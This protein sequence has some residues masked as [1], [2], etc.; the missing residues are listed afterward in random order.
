MDGKRI[1]HV[2]FAPP[3][4]AYDTFQAAIAASIEFN[5]TAEW[6]EVSRRI[7]GRRITDINFADDILQ[8][9]LDNSSCVRF[10]LEQNRIVPKWCDRPT[11]VFYSSSLTPMKSS[12]KLSV[13]ESI[14][15]WNPTDLIRKLI[16]RT[17]HY[18]TTHH[19]CFSVDVGNA[20]ALWVSPM[21]VEELNRSVIYFEIDIE[22]DD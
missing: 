21:F 6:Q 5:R 3:E 13:N 7:E 9:A 1:Y 17:I 4:P 8:I 19:H 10:E 15:D 20:R 18:F 2:R 11:H 14:Y 16:A 22:F 12:L